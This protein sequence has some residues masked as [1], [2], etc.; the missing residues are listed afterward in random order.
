MSASSLD[1]DSA[2]ASSEY[3]AAVTA[4]VRF[5]FSP[6]GVS[7]LAKCHQGREGDLIFLAVISQKN[8]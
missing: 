6:L 2:L 5:Y 1:Q 7:P 3:Y 8:K 4:L